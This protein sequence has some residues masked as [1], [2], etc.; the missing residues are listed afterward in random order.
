MTHGRHITKRKPGDP[1]Y[2]PKWSGVSYEP[3]CDYGC[4][5]PDCNEELHLE[6]H[7]THYCPYCDGFKLKQRECP[8]G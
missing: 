2:N 1:F 4:R 8:N 3:H 5:C 7:D 6:G